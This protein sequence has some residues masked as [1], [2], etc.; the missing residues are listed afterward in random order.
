M[1]DWE[2]LMKFWPI[3]LLFGGHIL[4]TEQSRATFDLRIKSLE[5]RASEFRDETRKSR[6][7]TKD[8][9]DEIRGDIKEILG[10]LPR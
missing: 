6:E 1:I 3:G 5:E 9:L 2:G 4:R 10:K 8:T 7:E